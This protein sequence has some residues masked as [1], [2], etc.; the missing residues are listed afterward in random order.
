M[1]T[2]FALCRFV[3]YAA[4]VVLFG[5]C[6]MLALTAS[7]TVSLAVDARLG[8]TLRCAAIVG[9]LSVLFLLPLLTASI[10]EDWH[11]MANVGMLSTV[12]FETRYGQAWCL[13]MVAVL[14]VLAVFLTLRADRWALRT[15]TAGIALLPLG[16]SGHAA[17]NDGWP[18]VLHAA[19]DMLHGLAA[20]FWL[21]ALPVFLVLLDLWRE[22]ARR[23]QV[24]F[25]LMRLSRIGHVAVAVLLASGALNAWMILAPSGLD[26]SSLYAQLLAVKVV[27]AA[28]MVVLALV[29]RYRWV[30]RIRGTPDLALCEMRRN[31]I[32]ECAAG[33]AVL[34]LVGL[35]GLL[36]PH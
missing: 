3:A 13:R 4:S 14:L 15:A 20:A 7:R 28:A 5:A 19:G 2:A 24:T 35:L 12:A 8:R 11:A 34:A 31:T 21:G 9:A 25:A 27:L 30:P 6:A 17:M 36:P 32:L 29:N 10:A 33:A 23:K 16:L 26:F 18:G 1:L 22:P